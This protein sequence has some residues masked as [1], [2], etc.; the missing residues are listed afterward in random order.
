MSKR[1][2]LTKRDKLL[3]ELL[4]KDKIIDY[5]LEVEES[6]ENRIIVIYQSIIKLLHTAEKL[7]ID[8]NELIEPEE[9][10]SIK[11]FL[12]LKGIDPDD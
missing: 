9:L 6:E 3:L 11:K 12:T 5:Q 8:I 2:Y 10:L 7:S 4:F 1:S